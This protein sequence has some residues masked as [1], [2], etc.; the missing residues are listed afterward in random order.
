[1]GGCAN[2]LSAN[3]SFY[4]FAGGNYRDGLSGCFFRRA[5]DNRT[6]RSIYPDGFLPQINAKLTDLSLGAGLKGKFGSKW[7][8]DLSEVVGTNAFHLN[9][10]NTHNTSLGGIN[11]YTFPVAAV[12]QKTEMNDGTLHFTQAN[13]NFDLNRIFPSSFAAP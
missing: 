11:Q 6:V 13:T 5:S 10:K 12:Q 7:N 2:T 8:Y 1:M 4:V 3:T 9:M